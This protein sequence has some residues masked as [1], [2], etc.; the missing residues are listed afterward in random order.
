MVNNDRIVPVT[1][2]D[3][4]TL[5]ALILQLQLKAED[6]DL[7][8]LQPKDTVGN[9]VADEEAIYIASQPV[10][11]AEFEDGNGRLY[12]VAAFDFEGFTYNGESVST[13]GETVEPNASTLYC[14]ECEGGSVE[15]TKVGF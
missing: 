2:T 1:N 11:K 7:V 3:L 9:F 12:F 6:E 10:K 14:A 13:T 8:V 15:I 5:Y 4:L